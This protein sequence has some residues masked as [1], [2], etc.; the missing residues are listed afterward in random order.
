MLL[1]VILARQRRNMQSLN[2]NGY[3]IIAYLLLS[4]SLRTARIF[5]GKKKEEIPIY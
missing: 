3:Q 4:E 2:E 1:N 5:R